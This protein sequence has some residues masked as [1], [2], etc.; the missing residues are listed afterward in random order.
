MLAFQEHLFLA[1][2]IYSHV[3]VQV[4]VRANEESV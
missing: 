4:V 2:I 1:M 3:L